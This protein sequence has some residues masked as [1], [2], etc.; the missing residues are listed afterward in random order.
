MNPFVFHESSH[1]YGCGKKRRKF[2]CFEIQIMIYQG[3]SEFQRMKF[4]FWIPIPLFKLKVRDA[5]KNDSLLVIK[6]SFSTDNRLKFW[7]YLCM[8]IYE[9]LNRF[10]C[11]TIQKKIYELQSV[12]ESDPFVMIFLLKWNKNDLNRNR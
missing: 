7:I 4:I 8:H 5:K 9:A 11:T 10:E 12:I 6:L 3:F 1:G 2:T